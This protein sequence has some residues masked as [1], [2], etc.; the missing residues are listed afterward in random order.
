V[1]IDVKSFKIPIIE[2]G[3]GWLAVNKPVDLSVHNEPGQDLCSLLNSYFNED[4]NLS[5][6]IGFDP[7]FGFH[8][9]HRLDRTTSGLI[10]MACE[11][12]V[13]SFLGIQFQER[14]VRKT[15]HAILH[16]H[17]EVS[18]ESD[19]G[20]GSW[21]WPLSRKASGRKNPQGNEKRYPCQTRYKILGRSSHYTLAEMEPSTGRRHQ[22]RRHASLAKHPVIGDKRYSTSRS[23][24]YLKQR[25]R[26]HRLG[27][28]AFALELILPDEN[29]PRSITTNTLPSDMQ[30]LFD[31]DAE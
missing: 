17:L 8:A 6:R 26:F 28:H 14:A 21:D 18:A 15:Y 13:L 30:T 27:L 1:Q 9:V 11:K 4:A 25:V 22:I 19:D 3:S 7:S 5:G 29:S 31:K 24:K 16:G 23:V 20:W 2:H 10:L 12:A